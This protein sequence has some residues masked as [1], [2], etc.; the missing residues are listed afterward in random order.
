MLSAWLIHITETQ[1]EC[2]FERFECSGLASN[3]SMWTRKQC[4]CC[5]QSVGW[6]VELYNFLLPLLW[7]GKT[8]WYY[9]CR[10]VVGLH[11]RITRPLWKGMEALVAVCIVT[12]NLS[13]C[14][15]TLN[16]KYWI[17]VKCT[18]CLSQVITIY[19]VKR[20]SFKTHVMFFF[21]LYHCFQMIIPIRK[22]NKVAFCFCY[23]FG[24]IL[25]GNS[26]IWP[27]IK[28]GTVLWVF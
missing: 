27:T 25:C 24:D 12:V 15:V 1:Q 13:I 3:L 22:T 23:R 21:H 19:T 9:K 7:R 11:F 8:V 20:P 16:K 17:D 18:V 10:Q 26:N 4:L 14:V 28:S 2:Y 6:T 5:L